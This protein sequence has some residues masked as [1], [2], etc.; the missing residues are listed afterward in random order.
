MPKAIDLKT[1]RLVWQLLDETNCTIPHIAKSIPVSRKTVY[2]II[3][4]SHYWSKVMGKP[5]RKVQK[6][7]R[8]CEA[9]KAAIRGMREQKVPIKQICERL[10]VSKATVYRT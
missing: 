6:Q 9:T 8:H 2:R 3:E 10:G 5:R 4:G 7:T 1:A